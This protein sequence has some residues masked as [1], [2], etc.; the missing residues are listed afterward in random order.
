MAAPIVDPPDHLGHLWKE[1]VCVNCNLA[2]IKVPHIPK[3][4]G[5]AIRC[6][7]EDKGWTPRM[8]KWCPLCLKPFEG[9]RCC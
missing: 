3:S 2:M 8:P 9:E 1:G 5:W 7:N 4:D 6:S